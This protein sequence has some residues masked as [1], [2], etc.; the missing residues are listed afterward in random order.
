MTKYVVSGYIGFDNFG[1]EVIAQVLVSHLKSLHAEKI[2]LISSKPLKTSQIYGVESVGMLKF[3]SAIADSDVLISG[4]GSLLQDVTSLKSLIYYLVVIV[5]ALLFKKKVV[6]FAQGFTPFRTKLGEFLTKTV[7]KKCNSITVRDV[8]SKEMLNSWG[9][10]C[11]QIADPVFGIEIPNAEKRE[12]V[13]IQLRHTP[14]FN[15]CFLEKLAD[16]ISEQFGNKK[17]KLLSLQDALDLEIL[18][19]FSAMLKQRGIESKILSNLT[20]TE[21]VKEISGLEYLIGMRFHAL[22]VSSV[23]RVKTLGLAYDV[24]VENLSKQV[25]FCC[26]K[27]QDEDLNEAFENLIAT[28]SDKYSVP[29]FKFPGD[30]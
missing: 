29:E 22:L 10:M 2:T 30:M 11:K 9:I 26:I 1:D 19:T 23:A 3:F 13:G 4:G 12:G 7:L 16:I 24:K 27:M 6:I 15:I 25:G 8:N 20:T 5:T 18:Q 17:I 28:D 21:I 14:E